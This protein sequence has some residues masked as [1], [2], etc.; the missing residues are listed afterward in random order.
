MAGDVGLAMSYSFD[1]R[2]YKSGTSP[3]KQVGF[4]RGEFKYKYQW[5]YTFNV[6]PFD[7]NHLSLEVNLQLW[8]TG[9][10]LNEVYVVNNV[11]DLGDLWSDIPRH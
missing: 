5:S 2:P 6:S 8:P 11:L 3:G 9:A 10:V 1:G 4:A 7:P